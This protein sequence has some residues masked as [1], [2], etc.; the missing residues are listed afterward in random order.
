[1]Y[2]KFPLLQIVYVRTKP[3]TVVRTRVIELRALSAVPGL[4]EI[5]Y[6]VE[7]FSTPFLEGDLFYSSLEAFGAV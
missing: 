4:W 1:M 6:F 2:T 7:G 5:H 3:D